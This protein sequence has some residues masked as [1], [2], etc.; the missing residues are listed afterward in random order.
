MYTYTYVDTTVLI[1][2]NEKILSRIHVVVFPAADNS[3]LLDS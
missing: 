3:L 1:S 2:A